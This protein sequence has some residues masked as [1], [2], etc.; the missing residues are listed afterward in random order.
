MQTPNP[1]HFVSGAILIENLHSPCYV[2]FSAPIFI[3][4][5]ILGA[6]PTP[7]NFVY[8]DHA[9]IPFLPE[10]EFAAWESLKFENAIAPGSQSLIHSR[11]INFDNKTLQF[12]SNTAKLRLRILEPIEPKYEEPTKIMVMDYMTTKTR[13]R[14]L[15]LNSNNVSAP[16]LKTTF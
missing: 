2:E 4:F 16:G 6:S 7:D 11:A 10:V 5:F 14:V 1:D 3:E 12:S 13:I 9:Q 8:L 15:S